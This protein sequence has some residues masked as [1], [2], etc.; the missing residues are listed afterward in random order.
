MFHFYNQYNDK[1]PFNHI[2]CRYS[3]QNWQV[4]TFDF[5]TFS[6]G[7]KVQVCVSDVAE[8]ILAP[9][10]SYARRRILPSVAPQHTSGNVWLMPGQRPDR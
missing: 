3:G 5:G 7:H 6:V 8:N 9:S 10:G 1:I 4:G 2:V